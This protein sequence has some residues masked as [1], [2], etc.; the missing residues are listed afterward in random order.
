MSD[1]QV[2]RN[3]LSEYVKQNFPKKQ[4]EKVTFFDVTGYPHY[5]NVASNI[6]RFL[7]D[8]N[9]E[10]NFR[11]LWLRSLL[12]AYAKKANAQIRTKT[13][14]VHNIEREYSNGFEKRIDLLID[15][16][17]LV[18]VIENKIDASVYNPFDIYSKMAENYIRDNQIGD[19]EMVK[20]V[21]SVST[22]NL[23]DDTHFINV[24]YD[25]LFKNVKEHWWNYNPDAK[26]GIF[27]KDFITNLEKK[28][29]ETHMKLDEKWI[30]FVN[31]NGESLSDLFNK[32]QM[33]IDERVT[34]LRNLDEELSDIE[35]KKGVYNSKGSSYSSQF[36][37]IKLKD[38]A[39]VCFETYLMKSLTKKECEDYDKL[40]ISL[41]CRGN[42]QYDFSDVLKAIN[43]E[44]TRVRTTTGSGS[45]GKHHILDEINLTEEF[46]V[47]EIAEKIRTYVNK[48]VELCS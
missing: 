38:G 18:I 12:D 23:D 21:L 14:E 1:Y 8:T 40:Y 24:T 34:L 2:F 44:N 30:K 43:K 3:L 29:E 17:P 25:E 4:K 48:T 47:P 10:H 41:W 9:E 35:F 46:S 7:F 19:S 26:W 28:E 27:A 13:L 36:I 15:A 6:L 32:I 37:D 22:E 39:T 5:E 11:D 42:K 33:D 45:W 31:E 20:I 16:R